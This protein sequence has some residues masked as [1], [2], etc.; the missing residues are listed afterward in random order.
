[1]AMKTRR[2]QGRHAVRKTAWAV[3][4][5]M[6]VV[7][8]A[9]N[10]LYGHKL[11]PFLEHHFSKNRLPVYEEAVLRQAAARGSLSTILF[12]LGKEPLQSY[13]REFMLAAASNRDPAVVEFLFR[14]IDAVV[15][16]AAELEAAAAN[17]DETLE[18]LLGRLPIK[19]KEPP[20]PQQRLPSRKLAK[21]IVQNC[22]RIR[23]LHEA[24]DRSPEEHPMTTLDVQEL[25]TC[26][27]RN[28]HTIDMASCILKQFRKLHK[29]K[30]TSDMLSAAASNQRIA[31]EML[32]LLLNECNDND[33]EALITSEVLLSAASNGHE[34]PDAL[35]VL[36][37]ELKSKY[38]SGTTWVKIADAAKSNVVA[39]QETA[40]VFTEF[41]SR[42]VNYT[43]WDLNLI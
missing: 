12:L 33:V 40:R 18:C 17:S 28:L 36:L 6:L 34:A 38:F 23:T 16:G 29:A 42:L 7:A 5:D 2:Q 31:S 22:R 8:A 15:I 1:M 37:Y 27:A 4:K 20:P 24:A 21:L 26:A 9:G 32:R 19:A 41:M 35:R 39:G 13:T 43:V 14:R 30:I 10:K 25:V 3:S 11:L